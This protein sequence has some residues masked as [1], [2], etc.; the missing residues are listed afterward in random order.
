MTPVFE[1]RYLEN[2][3]SNMNMAFP[4]DGS[5]AHAVG[6]IAAGLHAD[7]SSTFPQTNWANPH[8][9][10]FHV[11]A[12]QMGKFPTSDVVMPA[13][14]KL[15]RIKWREFPMSDVVMPALLKLL[16]IKCGEYPMSDMVMPALLRRV[17]E[18]QDDLLEDLPLAFDLQLLLKEEED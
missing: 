5:M 1:Q 8:M 16:R 13:L 11:V 6:I 3:Q 4:G 10:R 14:L 9:H 18:L 15:V 17:K 7:S 12:N 2:R